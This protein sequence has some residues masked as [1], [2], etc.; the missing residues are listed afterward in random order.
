MAWSDAAKRCREQVMQR[1]CYPF[2]LVRNQ[3]LLCS[4]WQEKNYRRQE[5][6]ARGSVPQEPGGA[7]ATARGADAG[8]GTAPRALIDLRA[9][10]LWEQNMQ[11]L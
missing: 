2:T 1:E 8:A 4:R 10:C 11:G 5:G 6:E 7:E 9:R 3:L